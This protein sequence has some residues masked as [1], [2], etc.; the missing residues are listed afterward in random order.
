[1]CRS[2]TRTFLNEE[3]QE[4]KS[5]KKTEANVCHGLLRVKISPGAE[6]PTTFFALSFNPLPKNHDSIV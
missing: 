4:K 6:T 2:R 5:A 3:S 1:M